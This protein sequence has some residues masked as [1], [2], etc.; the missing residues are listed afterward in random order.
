MHMTQKEKELLQNI[1]VLFDKYDRKTIST[2]LVKLSSNALYDYLDARDGFF[3][4][5]A[6]KSQKRKIDSVQSDMDS[7]QA[8]LIKRV[9][10]LIKN[11]KIKHLDLEQ[12]LTRLY[13]N[14]PKVVF[15][16][17]SSDE[18]SKFLCQ[19]TISEVIEIE[20]SLMKLYSSKDTANS[21]DNWS[22]L[23]I[24]NDQSPSD[25]QK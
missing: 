9:L 11:I 10:R 12:V 17:S 20:S 18:I 24:K 6:P 22:S 14:D 21:L 13:P 3:K 4:E 15:N 23:I 25:S 1:L 7:D 2:A 8:Q 19:K 5:E 16:Y